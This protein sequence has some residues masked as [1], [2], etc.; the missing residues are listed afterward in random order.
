M[1]R[2]IIEVEGDNVSVSVETKET[3]VKTKSEESDVKTVSQ[4][5]RF[6]DD[7]CT[8][9][10][11]DAE[12]N[13]V[14]LRDVQRWCNMLLLKQGYLFLND[15]YEKLGIPKTKAGQIVGWIY[16]EKNTIGDNYVD[17]GLNNIRN[18][19]FLEGIENVVLLDFNVDGEIISRLE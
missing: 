19:D 14:Y 4:Y 9:W 15:V 18:E 12:Y 11:R 3:E 8:G 16:G 13:L 2:I 1:T 10:S 6:F 5:A 17:F 7:G